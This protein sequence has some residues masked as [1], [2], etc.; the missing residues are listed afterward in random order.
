MK[1]CYAPGNRQ[2]KPMLRI[3]NRFLQKSG[4]MVGTSISVEYTESLIIIRKQA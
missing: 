4:F 2:Q 1:I 3:I